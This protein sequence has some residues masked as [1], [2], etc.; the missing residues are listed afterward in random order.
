LVHVP[1]LIGGVRYALSQSRARLPGPRRARGQRRG[2]GWPS[3]LR[4]QGSGPK[5]LTQ[6][7]PAP[8]PGRR[9]P[10]GGDGL[11]ISGMAWLEQWER[12]FLGLDRLRRIYSGREG[13]SANAVYYLHSF[14]LNAYHLRDWIAEDGSTG[15]GPP[16][17]RRG[18][19]SLDGAQRVRRLRESTEACGPDTAPARSAD[20]RHSTGRDG[21]AARIRFGERR[22]RISLM[23]DLGR[24]TE[25]RRPRTSWGCRC[26]MDHLP[27]R[28]WPDLTPR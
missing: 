17:D 7:A 16:S 6:A 2:G 12:V 24:R 27:T 25:L 13:G 26:R 11:T 9:S 3:V 21:S 20:R 28:T 14:F 4:F 18:Y 23:D 19:P 5:H 8:R 10:V 15:I 1:G 22:H